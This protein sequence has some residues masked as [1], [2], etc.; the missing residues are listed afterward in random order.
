MIDI[1]GSMLEGGG[2]LLR[3]AVAYSAIIGESI[4]VHKIR[5]RREE[6]GLRPQHLTAVKAVAE[7]CS[8]TVEGL[9]IGS[10]EVVFHPGAIVGGK[11]RFDIGTAGSI[12][13]LLQCVA[14]V[15]AYAEKPTHLEV[16][17]GTSVRRSMPV[18]ML[19][20]VVWKA[21]EEMGFQGEL[22]IKREGFYPRGG[23]IVEADITPAKEL[24][25]LRCLE[26]VK[27][28]RIHGLSLCGRLPSHVAERQASAAESLLRAAGYRNLGIGREVSEGERRPLS[29]GSVICLWVAS[30]APYHFGSNAL[31]ERGKPAEV[32]GQEA[33]ESLLRQV[34]TGAN[35]DL[36]TTDNLII[37]CSLAEGQSVF[38]TSELT[39]HTLTAIRLAEIITQSRFEVEG[40]LGK[41]A[42]IKCQGIGC[43]NSTQSTC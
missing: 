5:A 26:S 25:P 31:G 39:M 2:Q 9:E 13:L 37:W 41:P 32:V 36:H 42:L 16:V 21:F 8:A 30:E 6:T 14:P 12:G 29:P 18:L 35:V 11:Y 33:A 27:P 20:E 4:R 17:G 7:L 19:K 22:Q 34:R 3:M 23:G 24:K 43:R 10:R 1:D 15:A 28:T 38:R 40:A